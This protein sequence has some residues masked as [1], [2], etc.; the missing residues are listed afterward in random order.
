MYEHKNE[1][2]N[3]MENIDYYE[4]RPLMDMN[5]FD[6]IIDLFKIFE[7]WQYDLSINSERD[8]NN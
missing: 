7:K 6:Q 5:D 8:I 3:D 1:T 4:G 2:T